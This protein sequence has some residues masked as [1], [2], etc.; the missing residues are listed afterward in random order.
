VAGDKI[1]RLELHG[2]GLRHIA[3]LCRGGAEK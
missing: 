3:G 2:N 1:D